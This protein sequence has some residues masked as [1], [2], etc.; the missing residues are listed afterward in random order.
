MSAG[1]W[2]A[3]ADPCGG[4]RRRPSSWPCLLPLAALVTSVPTASAVAAGWR[5]EGRRRRTFVGGERRMQR[6]RGRKERSN[7]EECAVVWR[8]GGVLVSTNQVKARWIVC[9]FIHARS[10]WIICLAVGSVSVRH[11]YCNYPWRTTLPMCTS[12]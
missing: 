8:I 12:K 10:R 11:E 2:A 7:R 9:F 5:E 1:M 4:R 3:I 6:G